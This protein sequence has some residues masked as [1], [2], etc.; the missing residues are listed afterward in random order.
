MLPEDFKA[1]IFFETNRLRQL[2]STAKAALSRPELKKDSWDAAAAGKLISDL[3]G[4]LE[5]LLRKK[6]RAENTPMPQG[7]D[8]HLVMLNGFL[9]DPAFQSAWSES[10]KALLLRYLRFRHRFVHGYGHELSWEMV[11][12]PLTDLPAIAEAL[13]KAWEQWA[14]HP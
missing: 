5:S 7:P 11:Q 6:S 12:E 4:G 13:A 14:N 1:D 9:E 2:A 8:W 3:I 10:Q